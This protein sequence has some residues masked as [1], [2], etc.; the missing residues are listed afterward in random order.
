MISKTSFS[1]RLSFNA[2]L[3]CIQHSKTF[4]YREISKLTKV[5]R[6][7]DQKQQKKKAFGILTN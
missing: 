2:H 5:L 1:K 4:I 3:A 7:Y 6:L